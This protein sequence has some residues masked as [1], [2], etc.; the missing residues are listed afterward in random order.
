MGVF[1]RPLGARRGL[2]GRSAH[3]DA[4]WRGKTPLLKDAIAKY[5]PN[6]A[7]CSK[8]RWLETLPA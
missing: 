1:L 3:D 6:V 5:T 2:Q 7:K 8:F 4:V